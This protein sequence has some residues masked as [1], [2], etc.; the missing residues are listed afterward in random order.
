MV[1]EY[2][3]NLHPRLLVKNVLVVHIDCDLYGGAMLALV[4]L[5]PFMTKGTILIFDEF[6]DRENEFKAFTDWQRIYRKNIRIVGE[7]ENYAQIGI[8]LQ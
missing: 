6:F 2:P 3:P 1:R 7:V 5:A 4:H 8:Q